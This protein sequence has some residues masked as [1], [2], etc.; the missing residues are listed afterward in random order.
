MANHWISNIPSLFFLDWV[1]PR[2][3]IWSDIRQDTIERS[4]MICHRWLIIGRHR[5]F[6]LYRMKF[7]SLRIDEEKTG[8]VEFQNLTDQKILRHSREIDD[9]EEI[10]SLRHTQ[11]Q[12]R[13]DLRRT[14]RSPQR[15]SSTSSSQRRQRTNQSFEERQIFATVNDRERFRE[16]PVL[17]FA[18]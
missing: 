18:D 5:I 7:S 13:Q 2:Q 14:S 1:I 11:R 16:E 8:S 17:L 4:R 9:R 3:C 15:T 12:D 6:N 10:V